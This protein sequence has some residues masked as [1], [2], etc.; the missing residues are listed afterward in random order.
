MSFL[1]L[2][3]AWIIGLIAAF[4]AN[5]I[6]KKSI[7]TYFNRIHSGASTEWARGLRDFA[8]EN[9]GRHAIPIAA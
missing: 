8:Q 3:H 1:E 9:Y 2:V 6:D 5:A 4:L 7:N